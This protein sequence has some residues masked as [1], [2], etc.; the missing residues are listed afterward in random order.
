MRDSYCGFIALYVSSNLRVLVAVF[1]SN[2]QLLKL[3]KV[4]K[5]K[6]LLD[7]YGLPI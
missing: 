1:V 7:E 4:G 3:F 6:M 2:S 5:Y